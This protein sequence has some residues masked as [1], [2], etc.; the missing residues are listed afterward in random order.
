M[1]LKAGRIVFFLE[2]VTLPFHLSQEM[3]F[4]FNYVQYIFNVILNLL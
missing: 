3:T 2:F 4:F 1:S